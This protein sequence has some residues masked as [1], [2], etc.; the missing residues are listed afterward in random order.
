MF[1]ITLQRRRRKFLLVYACLVIFTFGK[2]VSREIFSD[3]FFHQIGVPPFLPEKHFFPD[4]RTT[5][6]LKKRWYIPSKNNTDRESSK[7]VREVQIHS[8]AA[9]G[10]SA[11]SPLR[12]RFPTLR[13]VHG[14]AWPCGLRV[15]F[16]F[17]QTRHQ[18]VAFY[19]LGTNKPFA[20][21]WGYGHATT[22]RI[23]FDLEMCL[24]WVCELRSKVVGREFGPSPADFELSRP[25]EMVPSPSGRG[26]TV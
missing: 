12:D 2:W 19:Y 17:V 13:V 3:F 20:R 1:S 23:E 6:F 11:K 25:P 4:R 16:Q 10:G 18:G 8:S 22:R 15:H 9:P 21:V 5:F 7:S 26:E 24:G 14:P